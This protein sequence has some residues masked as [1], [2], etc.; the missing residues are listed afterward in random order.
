MTEA[1]AKATPLSPGFSI[2]IDEAKP[3]LTKAAHKQYRS[4]VAMVTYL[5][6]TTRP[7][8]AHAA[9]QLGRVQHRPDESHFNQLKH[10]IA[11]IKGT[12]GHGLAYGRVKDEFTDKLMCFADSSWADC[13]TT[14]RSSH[15]YVAFLNGAPV[16]WHARRTRF[17][18][19][20]T[21]EAEIDAATEATKDIIHI[22]AVMQELQQQ[23]DE[24]TALG[25]DNQATIAMA[26]DINSTVTTRTK[27]IAA[28]YLWLRERIQAGDVVLEYCKTDDMIADIMTKSLDKTKFQLF[29]DQ[30]VR[31][32]AQNLAFKEDFMHGTNVYVQ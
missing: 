13:R 27:H 18:A 6:Y 1:K 3:P 12:R 4:G 17:V 26:E 21:A 11:Y 28:R 14:R 32:C 24:P 22:R 9:S 31:V 15:G 8:L 10:T 23:Q 5:S 29:R 7:D 19:L 20:S 30:L 16:G 2:H 25:Q